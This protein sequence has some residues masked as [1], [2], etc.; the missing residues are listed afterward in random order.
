FGDRQVR[1]FIRGTVKAL[2]QLA[3]LELAV[4][5]SID[6]GK[7]VW[8]QDA[9]SFVGIQFSVAVAVGCGDQSP[10]SIRGVNLQAAGR[11]RITGHTPLLTRPAHNRSRPGRPSLRRSSF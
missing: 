11:V 6:G 4:A 3:L 1:Q 2:H 8:E 7:I 5:V 9:K 10:G